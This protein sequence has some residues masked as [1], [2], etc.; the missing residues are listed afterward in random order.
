MV[1][2]LLA[3]ILIHPRLRA[4]CLAMLGARI[5]RNVRI[6]ECRFINL[7]NGFSNLRVGDDVHIGAG[8]LID[9]EGPVAIGNGSALSPRVTVLSHS[10]PGLAHG[11][12][13][14]ERWEPEARG[15]VI[16]DGCWIGACATILS[17]SI[18]EDRVVVG[19]GALVRGSLAADE[20]YVGVPAR[21][22]AR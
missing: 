22:T 17:G 12:P 7:R 18:V 13:L 6:Y 5:G 4:R 3:R 2:E 16:G 8:C 15:V 21:A 11:S 9:L 1:A 10:D 20:V 14:C 19:A